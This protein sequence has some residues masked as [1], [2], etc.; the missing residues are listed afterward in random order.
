[1][2]DEIKNE[3]REREREE[4]GGKLGKKPSTFGFPT[5]SS[6][7]TACL[8]SELS[9]TLSKSISRILPAKIKIRIKTTRK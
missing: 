8:F 6:V 4:V 5:S 1:M 9:V 3:E 7:A 2:L